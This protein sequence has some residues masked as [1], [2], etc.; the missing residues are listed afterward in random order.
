MN[1]DHNQNMLEGTS[2]QYFKSGNTCVN[3]LRV[4]RAAYTWNAVNVSQILFKHNMWIIERRNVSDGPRCGQQTTTNVR[5]SSLA[6]SILPATALLPLHHILAVSPNFRFPVTLSCQVNFAVRSAC[7]STGLEPWRVFA[8]LVA[9]LLLP[10]NSFCHFCV[11][12]LASPDT[13]WLLN[14]TDQEIKIKSYS[15]VVLLGCLQKLSAVR[16]SRVW[17]CANL[18]RT[19]IC[20]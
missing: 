18:F 6:I 2:G 13:F 20:F 19:L 4:R 7:L 10:N 5:C 11:T 14:S 3:A 15:V 17:T 8:V 9:I 1:G 12:C 16:F